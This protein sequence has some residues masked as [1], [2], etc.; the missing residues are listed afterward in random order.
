MSEIL[1]YLDTHTTCHH[2]AVD[3][4]VVEVWGEDLREHYLVTIDP[5]RINHLDI[6]TLEAMSAPFF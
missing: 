6:I 2:R 4:H 1:A 5:S 3:D